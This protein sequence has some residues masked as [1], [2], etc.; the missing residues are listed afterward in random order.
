M[1]AH[2][3]GAAPA[4]SS[5]SGT[6]S[7]EGLVDDEALGVAAVGD[8]AEMLVG[9]VVGEGR[10]AL[11]ELLL[12]VPARGAGAARVDHAAHRRQV[13]FL[14]L[15]DGAARPSSPGRRSRGPG[16]RDRRSAWSPATRS[17]P[18]AGPSGRPRRRGRPA[19]RPAAAGRGA[20]W[21]PARAASSRSRPRRPWPRTSLPPLRRLRQRRLRRLAHVRL[22]LRIPSNLGRGRSGS[23]AKR[24]NVV[25]KRARAEGTGADGGGDASWRS[26]P[27]ARSATPRSSAWKRSSAGHRSSRR[28]TAHT[29]LEGWRVRG[30]AGPRRSHRF[31]SRSTNTATRP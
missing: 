17:A 28:S 24:A 30:Y 7:D 27:M 19:A 13:A 29:E 25:A 16:R 6:R 5:R 18:G 1:P 10:R 15:A 2:R 11:A 8:A 3:S 20:G 12:P 4:G 9:R 14:E 26:G 23:L 31:P 21:W 22:P